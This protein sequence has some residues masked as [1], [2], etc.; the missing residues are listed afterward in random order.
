[1]AGAPQIALDWDGDGRTDVVVNVGGSWDLYRSEGNAVA[2]VLHTGVAVPGTGIFTVTDQNGDGLD[3]LVFA[4]SATGYA[5]YYGLHNGAFAPPDLAN[6]FADGFG[7]S[8]A[9]SY[10]SIAQAGADYS[11]DW[12]ATPSGYKNYLAPYYVVE[13]ATFSD[14]SNNS[15]GTYYNFFWYAD[16][17][18]NIQGRGFTGFRARQ[19]YDSRNGIWETW[20]Y[21]QAFPYIGML[22]AYW[23]AQTNIDNPMISSQ[24][25]TA[26]SLTLDSTAYNQRYFTYA[27]NVMDQAYEVG[28]SDNG[29]LESTTSTNY[30][31]DNYGNVT[32]AATT[33]TDNDSGSPYLNSTWTSTTVNTITPNT[34]TWCLNLPT[35]TTVTNSSSA[36]GG[37]AITRTVAFT[38]DYTD[39]RQTQRVIEPGS[40][41]Y[42]VTEAYGYD[43]F[44]NMSSD[45]V[46][47]VGMAAR[48]TSVN[49]GTTGQFP[50]TIT[51][52]LGQVVTLSH[53]PNSGALTGQTD[54][55][56]TTSNPLTTTWAYDNFARKVQETRQD[57]TYTVWTYYDCNSFGGCLV[58]PHAISLLDVVYNTDGSTK[59]ST[60]TYLDP[61][62]R[63]LM[64]YDVNLSGA[65]D[66]NE[67]RYDSLGRVA[68]RAMPCVGG[69]LTTLCPY[70][71]TYHYDMINRITDSERPISATNSSLQTTTYGYAGRT[72]TV[73][74]ALNNARTKITL[75]TGAMARS[76]DPSGYYQN[77]NYDAFGSL[78]SV[79]DSLSNTLKSV[80]YGYGIKAFPVASTDMDLGARSYTFDA[81]GEV[82]AYTDA[83][84]QS[85]SE[86]YDKLSRPLVRTEP[87]LTTTWTWGNSAASYNIGQLA[88]VSSVSSAG[89][90]T[91]AYAYDSKGRLSN[92]TITN[93]GDAAHAFDYTYSATTGLLTTLKYPTSA[94]PS[95]YR[96][97]AGYTYQ[98]GILQQI[99]DAA[100]PS[101][102]WWT[103]NTEN[104]R[105]QVTQETT[106]DLTGHPQVVTNK[107]YDAVTG[108]IGSIQTGVGGGATLQNESYLQDYLGNI[109]ERQN[110]NAGLTENFYYDTRY[111]L[112]HSTLGGTINL[113]MAYDATGNIT[114][115]SDVAAGAAWTYDPTH[116][117][118]VTQAGSSSFT[119][120]YDANGNA[121][122]R[123]GSAVT[124]TSY[125]YPSEIDS[126][127][128]KVTFAYGANRERWR[129]VYSSSGSETTYY[130]T[131]L[132]ERVVTSSQND[133]RHYIYAGGRPVVVIS[134]TSLGAIN[135]H[136]LLADHQGSISSIV[137]NATGTSYVAES[138][139]AYGN[140]RESSTWSGTPTSAELTAM[141][142]VTREG[143]TFQ[144][145]LGSMGLN[146]MNGRVEDAVTGRFL[147]PDPTVN[148]PANTQDYNRYSYVN[149]NPLSFADPT[150][151]DEVSAAVHQD[152]GQSVDTGN[153]DNDFPEIV[154]EGTVLLTPRL[155]LSTPA[156]T[157]PRHLMAISQSL[158]WL[159]THPKRPQLHRPSPDYHRS[160]F[161]RHGHRHLHLYPVPCKYRRQR[162]R[163][164]KNH[165]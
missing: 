10:S 106:E 78:L 58:G 123:N 53:D 137:A 60:T 77:F 160:L 29:L 93:P 103:A 96:L 14:P 8:V 152:D 143:Y 43:S 19:R 92:Q 148:A 67:L 157:P 119:Y 32:N 91:N 40:S 11:E 90:Q 13:S 136:S 25:Y 161:H 46:T 150:G 54:P 114:S 115:R 76:Q 122:T 72:S 71:T 83:K 84:S 116:K 63:P 139:T 86:T 37:A 34:S 88:S 147:S 156:N 44:G 121:K 129:M 138:F 81:L 57:G 163:K 30:T 66:R 45:T 154:V 95:T 87:D 135:V 61:L 104:P 47:G 41:T 22:Y 153:A 70:W 3:D 158:L 74:D 20:N 23:Q 18:M 125:N 24:T 111:R 149:N 131:P 56:F 2:P 75:V 5:L 39:C 101:T 12:P 133:W 27:S 85:F 113:Q 155:C 16:A 120:T 17:Q 7:N 26:A 65:Y 89:T 107:T 15:G 141:N 6:S 38:P 59:T 118:Q 100:T 69:S 28:G 128:E 134:R 49:W 105:G 64:T 130:A 33:T 48:A 4:N 99:F 21:Y 164:V 62:D 144:T 73:Q 55:N 1:M 42:K 165:L 94:S 124:W 36:P 80:S 112:D 126:P 142:G 31:Y 146:H 109:T 97:T 98:N 140:R 50:T 9:L 52:A 102:I 82:T 51:N 108:W 127:L 110:N 68:T 132:F 35:E 79:T 117:H 159:A 162:W 145:V 151:F